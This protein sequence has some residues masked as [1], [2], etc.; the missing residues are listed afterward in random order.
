MCYSAGDCLAYVDENPDQF[1]RLC[2]EGDARGDFPETRLVD[3]IT[4]DDGGNSAV[5]TERR[6]DYAAAIRWMR[7]PEINGGDRAME[8]IIAEARRK[9][10][11]AAI[12]EEYRNWATENL[13]AGSFGVRMEKDQQAREAK[14][15]RQVHAPK[16][17]LAG[18]TDGIGKR[19]VNLSAYSEDARQQ[20][21]G[22]LA[23]SR[24]DDELI[25]ED[26]KEV[27]IEVHKAI[28]DSKDQRWLSICDLIDF[29]GLQVANVQSTHDF[30]DILNIIGDDEHFVA[31]VLILKRPGYA[32]AIFGPT[33]DH[34]LIRR[35]ARQIKKESGK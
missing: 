8:P 16:P 18:P 5:S 2:R 9:R 27:E 22:K 24:D 7:T 25:D 11:I 30:E 34:E 26:D 23:P 20:F 33:M 32:P 15:A 3:L 14:K 6:A 19:P 1:D 10:G 35:V 29:V 4:K 28:L 17:V 21:A 13:S 31:N 12:A